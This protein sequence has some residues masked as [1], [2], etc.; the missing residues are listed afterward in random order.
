MNEPGKKAKIRQAQQRHQSHLFGDAVQKPS[1]QAA[2]S[3]VKR[4]GADLSQAAQAKQRR[5]SGD[6]TRKLEELRR[7]NARARAQQAPPAPPP[8]D[9]PEPRQAPDPEQPKARPQRQPQPQP[10]PSAQPHPAHSLKQVAERNDLAAAA[11]ANMEKHVRQRGDRGQQPQPQPQQQSQ[12]PQ[13]PPPAGQRPPGTRRPPSPEEL[14]RLL[15]QMADR[16]RQRRG[17]GAPPPSS[18]PRPRAP[19][20]GMPGRPEAAAEAAPMEAEP[21]PPDLVE[22]EKHTAEQ[23]AEILKE[24]QAREATVREDI[25]PIP[26]SDQQRAKEEA[27]EARVPIRT[28]ANSIDSGPLHEAIAQLQVAMRAQD[29][30]GQVGGVNQV[31]K[32][33]PHHPLYDPNAAQDDRRQIT[34]R[35]EEQS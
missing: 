30:R 27:V 24:L 17:S 7:R 18:S 8:Q 20:S 25:A 9:V 15:R 4:R 32:Q 26:Q 11:L 23:S 1:S 35:P 31:Q 21:P 14:D 16:A 2:D 19:M 13:A 28:E 5:L 29:P 6:E 12:Q 10:R 22:K 34:D 3:H 33:M